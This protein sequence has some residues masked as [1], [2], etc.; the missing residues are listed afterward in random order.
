M[1]EQTAEREALSPEKNKLDPGFWKHK[2]LEEFSAEEWEALC[3]GC[4]R[5]CLHKLE[6]V[7]SGALVHTRAACRLLDLESCRCADYQRRRQ[8]VPDCIVLDKSRSTFHWLPASC[9]YR[10]I[11][12]GRELEWWHPLVS[13]DPD[14][15]HSAGISV[16]DFA[17]PE[18]AIHPEE[19][20]RCLAPWI[21]DD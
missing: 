15:V 18:D 16:R 8:L 4:G 13:G 19:L 9:A 20:E 21:D 1:G 11:D 2:R 7:D 17:L 10:R 12:E 6:D 14:S 3:D 5:C